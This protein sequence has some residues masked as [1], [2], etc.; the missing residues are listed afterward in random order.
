MSKYKFIHLIWLI[1]AYLLF[2]TIHQVLVY[3]GLEETYK[4][5]ESYT[6]KVV[7]FDIKKIASQTNGYVVLEFQ[8]DGGETI[9]RKLSQ[10][11]ELASMLTDYSQIPV[12]YQNGAFEEIVLMPTYQEHRNMVLSNAFI[13]LIGLLIAIG[14]AWTASRYARRKSIE[15][16]QKLVFERV[17]K[18]TV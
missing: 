1:P 12:R 4:N 6:A 14:V 17:D 16:E 11:I 9:N 7:D 2:L 15:G 10:P 3:N 18:Q 13:S 8:T 5:G